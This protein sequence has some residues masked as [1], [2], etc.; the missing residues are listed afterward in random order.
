MTVEAL[1][2]RQLGARRAAWTRRLQKQCPTCPAKPGEYHRAD[3]FGGACNYSDA[4]S[5]RF[6]PPAPRRLWAW[7]DC[8]PDPDT[9]PPAPASA[10]AAGEWSSP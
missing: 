6:V 4:Y 3:C 5:N 7:R 2:P 8:G 10:S 1:T 9:M